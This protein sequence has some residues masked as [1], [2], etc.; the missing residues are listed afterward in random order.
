MIVLTAER[1]FDGQFALAA[2]KAIIAKHPGSHML[3]VRV[4]ASTLRLGPEFLAAATPACLAALSE[5][6]DVTVSG[7]AQAA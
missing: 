5:W 2:I 6:G 4:G 1:T 7:E 3:I